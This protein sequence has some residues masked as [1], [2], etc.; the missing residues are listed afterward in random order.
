M[1]PGIKSR[2]AVSN[3]LLSCLWSLC[4]ALVKLFLGPCFP[5]CWCN[6]TVCSGP[7]GTFLAS[8]SLNLGCL[9][10]LF[11]AL[12]PFELTRGVL[13]EL[14]FLTP[15]VGGAACG[16]V[17]SWRPFRPRADS[18][19]VFGTFELL[20][21]FP[22]TVCCPVF[23]TVVISA[24]IPLQCEVQI[25]WRGC[26]AGAGKRHQVWPWRQLLFLRTDHP[27]TFFF[28]LNVPFG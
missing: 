6:C 15:A 3:A 7:L 4:S 14:C 19:A 9:S 2:L 13:T 27:G 12:V 20:C 1:L 25:W 21:V 24:F 23:R 11:S 16:S 22:I 8:L 26:S 18:C 10:E 17:H 28:L 5:A